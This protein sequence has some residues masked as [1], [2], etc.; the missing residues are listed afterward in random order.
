MLCGG[1]IGQC[2]LLADAHEVLQRDE[3]RQFLDQNKIFTKSLNEL[4]T[5]FPKLTEIGFC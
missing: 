2:Q 1:F 5:T 4:K 3:R